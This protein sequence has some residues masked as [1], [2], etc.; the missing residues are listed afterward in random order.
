[1]ASEADKKKAQALVEEADRLYQTVKTPQAQKIFA[2][3]ILPKMTEAINLDAENFVAWSNRGNAK[4]ALGDH[5]G[6]ID[7]CTKAIEIESTF[8][9]AWVNRASAKN[10]LGDHQ[11]AVDDC[12]EAIKINPKEAFAWNNRGFAKSE[13]GNHQDAIDD[14]N[15]AIEI[16]SKDPVTW[17]NRGNAKSELGGHQGAIKDYNEAIELN[18]KYAPAWNSRG[19]A[20]SSLGD[21]QGA[22]DDYTKATELESEFA[23]AWNNRGLAKYRLGKYDDALKDLDEAL[24]LEPDN[25][26][27]QRNRQ[28][29]LLAIESEKSK[30]ETFE[31]EREHHRRLKAKAR[32]FRKK[33]NE[34]IQERNRLFCI[35][36]ATIAG[37]ALCLFVFLWLVFCFS[38]EGDFT[39][40]FEHP[41]GLLPYFALL[42][43]IL[44]LFIWRISINTKEAERNLTLAEDYGGRLT[45]EL[46]L[47]RF[48]TEER[49]RREF[50][51]KYI[52]Y[53]MYNN[54]SE[55]MIRLANKPTNQ[56]EL[57]QV[58]QIRNII[59]NTPTDPQ[60]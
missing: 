53:W 13:L 30:G 54:P 26:T 31:K 25:E 34:C 18:S 19:N 7:D 38:D 42:F 43:V 23:T 4:N 9:K 49:D 36:L 47:E 11:G 50:A 45:A 8:I 6:A 21:H 39:D 27:T 32:Y 15:E 44:S 60:S 37:Y 14:F 40:L 24:S 58:E 20:K 51:Q 16:D 22:I 46:Y 56:P 33:H 17:N 48:L 52:V 3:K 5:Q 29:V 1:M 28:A 55:T 2:K 59:K 10:N 12:T 57:P 35:A 41:F